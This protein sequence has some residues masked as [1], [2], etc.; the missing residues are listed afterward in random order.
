M[1]TLHDR[2]AH[3]CK[4]HENSV[5]ANALKKSH[6]NSTGFHH[7]RRWEKGKNLPCNRLF[8][9][10]WMH[11]TCPQ[12]ISLLPCALY[13]ISKSL[14]KCSG[15]QRHMFNE[16]KLSSR[17]SCLR[18]YAEE[19]SEFN[20]GS[21]AWLDLS[22]MSRTST[23]EM[24]DSRLQLVTVSL[25]LSGFILAAHPHSR[26]DAH[27]QLV[28]APSVRNLQLMCLI[29]WVWLGDLCVAPFTISLPNSFGLVFSGTGIKNI[30]DSSIID[31]HSEKFNK[32][33]S[34]VCMY[35]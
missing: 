29:T 30:N 4:I 24:D 15:Q 25:G 13:T 21:M 23:P 12:K 26:G 10:P 7:L 16:R 20:R 35:I 3:Q 28:I 8:N 34:A 14:V 6:S 19:L 22:V 9:A 33:A 32:D 31:K 5:S 1:H 18:K 27:Q 17:H 2:S 11:V